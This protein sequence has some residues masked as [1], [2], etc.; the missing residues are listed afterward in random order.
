MKYKALYRKYRPKLFDELVGQENIVS[1]LKNSIIHNK[2]GHAYLFSGPR[3]T[4][5]TSTAKIFASVINCENPMD[6]KQCGKCAICKTNDNIDIIEIDAASNNGVDE[7][8]EIRSNAKLLPSIGKYKIYII[9]EV[10]MLSTGAFNALLKTLEEPP[11]HVIFILATTELHKVPL[12]IISRCQK[13]EFKKLTSKVIYNKLLEISTKEN[14]KIQKDALELI[15]EL[16]DGGLRDAINLLDQVCSITETE[17]TIEDVCNTSGIVSPKENE[18]FLELLENDSINEILG[19]ISK[20][21]N[22]GKD[23][24][25]FSERFVDYLRNL[26]VNNTL[27]G[28][29]YD[30]EKYIKIIYSFIELTNTL[31]NALNQKILFEIKMLE[32]S[33][34]KNMKLENNYDEKQ[35]EKNIQV[36]KTAEKVEEQKKIEISDGDEKLNKIRVNNALATAN[37]KILK[38][39]LE[40]YSSISN[41]MT[42]KKYS[43]SAILLAN[44]NLVVASDAYV[45]ISVED[46]SL[47]SSLKQNIKNIE[48]LFK[49]I[50]QRDI[51][52]SFLTIKEWNEE[53]NKYMTNLKNNIKY[54][55]IEE[56][57]ISRKKIKNSSIIEETAVD[58]FGEDMIKYN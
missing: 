14:L 22:N 11:K 53:K 31:K 36:E 48:N 28:V 7:I 21:D 13:F 16:S 24:L 47:K 10:H 57:K 29:E 51:K 9:D 19:F 30:K 42:D 34:S 38:S 35:L 54:E 12:T 58:I 45:I 56:P 44:S 18:R 27:N 2:I 52:P 17:V 3:G 5:K 33:K 20:L 39:M 23:Y 4:G 26:M 40:Q 41:Y 32:L 8:R 43:N 49:E 37:K 15:S 55:I 46:Y 6:A 25:L 1:I 50:Y